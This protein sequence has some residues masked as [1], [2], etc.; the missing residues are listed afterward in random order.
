MAADRSGPGGAR[1]TD[2]GVVVAD[3]W[4]GQGAGPALVR[5]LMTRARARGVTSVTMDVLHG[6]HRALAMIAGIWPSAC[7]RRTR[8]YETIW[9]QLGQRQAPAGRRERA[10]GAALLTS[11]G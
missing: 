3:A 11:I 6:N 9:V 1:M 10:P 2:I 8:D 7:K 4:Q 5:A